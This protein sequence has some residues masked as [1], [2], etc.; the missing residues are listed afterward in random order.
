MGLIGLDA[1]GPGTQ[2]PVLDRQTYS[3]AGVATEDMLLNNAAIQ[4]REFNKI[5][6][7]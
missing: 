7:L 2:G 1:R 3:S 5:A 4:G 6:D